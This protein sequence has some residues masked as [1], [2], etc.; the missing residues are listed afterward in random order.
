MIS[1]HG[2]ENRTGRFGRTAMKL[3][4]PDASTKPASDAAHL[5][6]KTLGG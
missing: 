3:I 4:V 1:E 6:D 5:T 2:Q